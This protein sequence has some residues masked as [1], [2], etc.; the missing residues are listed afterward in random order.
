MKD[1]YIDGDHGAFNVKKNDKGYWWGA[2]RDPDRLS[3]P[4]AGAC[5]EMPFWVDTGDEPPADI[6]NTITPELLAQLAYE[7][8]RIPEGTA[9]L[10]P[11]DDNQV[12]N[13][14]TWVSL[15]EATFHPVSAT[16][17]VEVLD[18]SATTTARPVRVHIDPGTGDAVTYPESGECPLG[19]GGIGQER[20]AGAEGPPPC[21]VE[22]LRSSEATGPYPFQATVTWEVSWTGTNNPDPAELPAGTFGTPQDVTV[23]EIQ[24][25][26]R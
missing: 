9:T 16:A 20:P 12:V 15:D 11:A 26:V 22:Y 17:S 8:I 4:T 2:Y 19:D 5:N 7:E 6:E 23:K 25:V 1:K 3:D 10:Q 21:G 18:I 24:S 13:L 14:P